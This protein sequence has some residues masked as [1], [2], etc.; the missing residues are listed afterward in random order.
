MIIKEVRPVVIPVVIGGFWRAFNK[1]GLRF[2]KK[3]TCLS[4]QF[5]APLQ[6]DYEASA[7]QIMEQI[8]D[9]IEQSKQ[10]MLQGRHHRLALA[11]NP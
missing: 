5:K 10:F 9:A 7:E 3:G 6:I 4:V 2:K 8:M 11:T 1:K